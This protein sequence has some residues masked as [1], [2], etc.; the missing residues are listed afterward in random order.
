MARTPTLAPRVLYVAIPVIVTILF[1]AAL[2]SIFLAYGRHESVLLTVFVVE[3][4]LAT[5]AGGIWTWLSW[6]WGHSAT[7]AMAARYR[8]L[9]ELV[10][11][12]GDQSHLD[13][14][15]VTLLIHH[16]YSSDDGGD[17]DV[18]VRVPA[19][20]PDELELVTRLPAGA[21]A[22]ELF[23]LHS[24]RQVVR[25]RFAPVLVTGDRV[26][27]DRGQRR[28]REPGLRAFLAR[29]RAARAGAGAGVASLE[30]LDELLLQLRAA[31]DK[32]GLADVI[33]LRRR[34]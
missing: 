34:G 32:T 22:G 5:V 29:A 27:V 25:H 11:E 9:R 16:D 8:Q 1:V 3:A 7:R 19:H 15:G 31:L 12:A 14:A 4:T 23:V 20:L 24:Y 13:A 17:C 10:D 28:R 2:G 26:V 6:C 18:L 33:P 21:Q 30:Q